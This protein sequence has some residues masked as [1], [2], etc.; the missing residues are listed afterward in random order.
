MKDPPPDL[1]SL[2]RL[3]HQVPGILTDLHKKQEQLIRGLATKVGTYEERIEMLETENAN[4]QEHVSVKS[5]SF[6]EELHT[7]FTAMEERMSSQENKIAALTSRDEL[8]QQ[9]ICGTHENTESRE[10]LMPSA[11]HPT[12]LSEHLNITHD[13]SK[14]VSQEPMSALNENYNQRE[15]QEPANAFD[16]FNE[17]SSQEPMLSLDELGQRTSQEPTDMFDGLDHQHIQDS[18]DALDGLDHTS[19]LEGIAIRQ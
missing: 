10:T 5:K 2:N 4:L 9:Q 18:L 15:S 7:K 11:N 19:T 14:S 1:E 8:L 3:L 16:A 13:R 12:P 6:A 17:W